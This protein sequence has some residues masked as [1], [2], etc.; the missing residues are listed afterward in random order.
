MRK[1]TT[2]RQLKT[3]NVSDTYIP[4]LSSVVDVLRN[5]SSGYVTST[6][7]N[8]ET[9]LMINPWIERIIRYDITNNRYDRYEP[10]TR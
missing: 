5:V 7:D 4:K 6:R 10:E 8:P 9:A 1:P 3:F 2:K